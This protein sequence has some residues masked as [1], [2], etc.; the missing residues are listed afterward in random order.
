MT[1]PPA[2]V[3]Q[4]ADAAQDQRA[5]DALA[6]LGLGDQQRAQPF[7]AELTS[8]STGSCA[9]R[10]DQRGPAGELRELAHE[11]AGPVGDDQRRAC[12]IRRAA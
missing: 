1:G 9:M 6:E 3:S 7:R 12:R 11:L 2:P 5:H 8:A 4:Q 10:I